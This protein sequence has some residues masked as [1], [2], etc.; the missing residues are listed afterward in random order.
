MGYLYGQVTSHGNIQ[1]CGGGT[2]NLK[3]Y[4]HTYK[5]I[6]VKI[7]SGVFL[8]MVRHWGCVEPGYCLEGV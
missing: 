4:S 3:A 6:R 7:W 2:N 8:L 1:T 5:A